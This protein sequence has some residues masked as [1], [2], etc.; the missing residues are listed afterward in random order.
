MAEIDL[1]G[2]AVKSKAGNTLVVGQRGMLRFDM[3]RV[4][5]I[6][7]ASFDHP[8][9]EGELSRRRRA[10][11][12]VSCVAES[13]G[14]VVGYCVYSSHRASIELVRL[15]VV[16]DPNFRR[17]GI[18]TQMINRLKTL[19]S[20]DGRR[21]IMLFVRETNLV[22]QMFFRSQGFLVYEDSDNRA[23]ILR[24]YHQDT[25]EDAYLMRYYL[26]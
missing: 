4:I 16:A 9:D 2:F 18:A 22:A 12:A 23:E 6:E 13:R 5:E 25:G 10:K 8:W 17:R 3:P 24:G 7:A 14:K 11:G 21:Q 20:D 1:S 26:S 15:A 19:L